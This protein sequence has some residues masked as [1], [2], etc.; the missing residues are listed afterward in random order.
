M[1]MW[2]SAQRVELAVGHPPTPPP[3]AVSIV[4]VG[5]TGALSR[6]QAKKSFFEAWPD[7]NTPILSPPKAV[8]SVMSSAPMLVVGIVTN[9]N[10][11]P[12]GAV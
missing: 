9:E 12:P 11:V 4:H 10:D 7:Q 1:F 6:R 8:T 3:Y 5:G 2:S